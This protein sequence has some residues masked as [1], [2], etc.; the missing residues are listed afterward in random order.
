ML[1]DGSNLASTLRELKRTQEERV[2]QALRV[3]VENLNDYSIE[4]VNGSLVTKLHYVTQNGRQLKRSSNLFSE[5]DGTIRML[6]ILAAVYQERYLSPLIIEEPEKAIYP[7]ALAVYSDVLQEAAFSY[8]VFVTTHSPD[9]ITE[10]P[11]DTLRVVEKDPNDD[12]T[13]VGPISEHQYEAI[14]EHL[15]SAGVLMR[16]EGLERETGE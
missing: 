5:A 1:E 11:P 7:D 4:Q 9:L 8:Q 13:K 10:L 12:V 16:V 2:V 15:F 14:E 3:V 6:A